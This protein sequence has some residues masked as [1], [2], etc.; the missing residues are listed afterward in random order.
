MKKILSSIISVVF[1]LSMT[2]AVVSAQSYNPNGGCDITVTLKKADPANVVKDGIIGEGEYEKFDADL[3]PDSTNLTLVFGNNA[4][5]Y[6]PAEE[7]LGTME[8]YFSWDEV[9]GFN[10]AVKCT[11]PEYDQT[12]P[13]GT[14]EKP[15]D[16][17]LCNLGLQVECAPAETRGELPLFYYAISRNAKTGEYMEGH[18]N[19]LGNTGSYDPNPGTDFEVAFGADGSVIYEWSIPF[20]NFTTTE[21][22]NGMRFGFTLCSVAGTDTPDGD[23][24]NYNC[25][26]VSFGE[27]GYMVDQRYAPSHAVATLSDEQIAGG[28]TGGDTT[29]PG[30]Q[31]DDTTPG[32]DNPGTDPVVTDDP[33]TDPVVTDNP[34]TDPVTPDNPTEGGSDNPTE[35]GNNVPSNN[36]K[37]PSTADPIVIMAIASAVSACGFAVSK[38]RK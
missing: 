26:G 22:A 15:G 23:E 30:T 31:P 5:M 3:S 25:Y 9:H 35:N 32:T 1:V 7:M 36:N 24:K 8:Y 37:A 20:A 10:F 38:K 28:T 4:A 11:P 12:I 6:T 18:Y 16:Q 29:N 17:F 27:Y 14:G 19:Q 33:G 2:A 13:V 34:G 21:V